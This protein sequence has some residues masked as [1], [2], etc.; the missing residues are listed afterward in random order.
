LSFYFSNFIRQTK[1]IWSLGP[2]IILVSAVSDFF[3]TLASSPS[4]AVSQVLASDSI[5]RL[6]GAMLDIDRDDTSAMAA[7]AVSILDS[8]LD[9][10]RFGLGD[11]AFAA[12]APGLFHLLD[13]SKD[14]DILQV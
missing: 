2:D 4:P 3:E 7:S 5:P 11:A 9:G 12:F 6:A 1:S 13:K 10:Q 8:L 14:R